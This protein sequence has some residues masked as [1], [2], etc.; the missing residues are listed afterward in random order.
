MSTGST[1]LSQLHSRRL[2]NHCVD[3]WVLWNSNG[4]DRLWCKQHKTFFIF[5]AHSGPSGKTRHWEIECNSKSKVYLTK[6][7]LTACMTWVYLHKC[8][9]LPIEILVISISKF[10]IKCHSSSCGGVV[11][12]P[13][14]H[15]VFDRS[16]VHLPEWGEKTQTAHVEAS[17]FL[18]M[19][20]PQVAVITNGAV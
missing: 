17:Q 18:T 4:R 1:Q 7:P 6:C 15:W 12:C 20:W 5:L 3:S 10:M 11:V 13:S 9:I 19:T 8:L 16:P 14:W 2:K